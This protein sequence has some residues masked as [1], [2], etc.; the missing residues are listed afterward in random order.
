MHGAI[1]SLGPCWAQWDSNRDELHQIGVLVRAAC[2][3][4]VRKIRWGKAQFPWHN[5]V[6][7]ETQKRKV[8][9]LVLRYH[10]I[11]ARHR[12]DIGTNEEFKVKLTPEHDKPMYT[13]GPPTP[14]HLR[15]EVLV[16]LAL[17]QYWGIITTLKYSKYSSPLFQC[18]LVLQQQ[19]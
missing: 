15:D 19:N 12:L 8:E 6:F 4:S 14:I 3:G 13:Q 9:E 2:Y 11:F 1:G 7:N 5:S 16:E 18:P 10:H 17:F